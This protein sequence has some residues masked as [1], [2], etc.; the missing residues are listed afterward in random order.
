[1]SDDVSQYA[2]L[3]NPTT[4]PV[5]RTAV[6][7]ALQ[8]VPPLW[9]VAEF[10]RALGAIRRSDAAYALDL[11]RTMLLVAPFTGGGPRLVSLYRQA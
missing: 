9:R 2:R 11:L 10:V 6:G 5:W 3:A 4:Q 8:R 1:M 7:S